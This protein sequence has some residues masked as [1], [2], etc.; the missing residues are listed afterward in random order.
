MNYQRKQFRALCEGITTSPP[1]L[2][3]GTANYPFLQNV[4]T[5][6]QGV[7]ETRPG[8]VRLNASALADTNV[9]SLRR[10]NDAVTGASFRMVGAGTSLYTQNTST[11]AMTLRASG[12]S[13]APLSS[14]I[15]RPEQSPQAWM[16]LT[17]GTKAG[18]LGIVASVPTYYNWGIASPNEAPAAALTAPAA[19]E[20][21]WFDASAGWAGSGAAAGAIGTTNRINTTI[22]QILYDAGSTGYASCAPASMD[23]NFQPGVRVR[24]NSGG[25]TDEYVLINSVYPAPSSTTISDI[26]Y[27]SGSTGACTI[28][29]AAASAGLVVNSLLRLNA[30]ENVRVQAISVGPDGLPSIRT[31]TTGTFS[32]GQ[33]VDGL[34][35]FRAYFAA[36]H[37][38]AETITDVALT[39]AISGSGLTHLTR[40]SALNLSKV[41]A[42]PVQDS[43][44]IHISIRVDNLAGFTE[45][46]IRL[47][48]DGATNDFTRNYFTFSF[49]P[50]DLTPALSQTAT[51][52]S[53]QQEALA[54]SNVQSIYARKYSDIYGPQDRDPFLGDYYNDYSTLSGISTGGSDVPL[55]GQTVTGNNQWTELRFKVGQLNRVGSDTTR[56]LANV[57]AIR[58]SFNAT[59]AINVQLD[60]WWVG[61]TYGPDVG[62]TGKSYVYC[63]RARSSITGARSNPSPPMRVGLSPRRERVQVTLTQHADAQVDYLDV[64]RFGGSLIN[65]RYI[66]SVSNGVSPVFNDDYPDSVVLANEGLEFDNYQ[67]FP[68]HDTPHSGVVSVKGNIVEWVSGDKFN[69]AW[70]RGTQI[71]INGIPYT[72]YARPSSDQRVELGEN[73]GS[74]TSVSYSVPEGL[75]AGQPLEHVWGPFGE[76]QTGIFIF[77]CGNSQQPGTLFW[78]RADSP[79]TASDINQL[80]ITSP[81]EPLIAGGMY[82]GRPF[83]YSSERMFFIYPALEST[84][85]TDGVPEER[86]SFRAQE[87]A[88]SKGLISRHALA[89]GPKIYFMARDGVYESEGGEPRLISG[90][91]I[92]IFGHDGQNGVTTN[93]IP[94][95]DLSQ[96]NKLRLSYYD[97]YLYVN[98]Q[99]VAAPQRTLI[100]DTR[101]RGW[102]LDTYIPGVN[103]HY[104][105]EGK[106]LHSLILAAT[107]GRTYALSGTSDQ[108]VGIPCVV[109]WPTWDGGD[110]RPLK[111]YGDVAFDL[112]T[113]AS[114]LIPITA[115]FYLDSYQTLL[116][117]QT[118]VR[119]TTGRE[120]QAL[121]LQSGAGAFAHDL[122]FQLSWTQVGANQV[123]LYGADISW[124]P[125]PEASSSRYT[126]WFETGLGT[127]WW[128]GLRLH[129]NTYGQ[130]RSIRVQYQDDTGAVINGPDLTF[131]LNGETVVTRSWTPF[132]A[133]KVRLAPLD[134]LPWTVLGVEWVTEPEPDLATTWTSQPTGHGLPGWQHIREVWIPLR[135]TA[136]AALTITVDGIAYN[137]SIG[138]TG[139]ALNKVWLPTGGLKGRIFQYSITEPTTGVRVYQKDIEVRCKSWGTSGGYQIVR[140]LGDAHNVNGALL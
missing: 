113:T 111:L 54:R 127:R 77:G 26:S 112:E 136:S 53:T 98:Y 15:A 68:V 133:R 120:W 96:I 10:L 16:Y 27:D 74:Q 75:V 90:G 9:H 42:R 6:T 76:G 45:G 140:P 71:V 14:V 35:S 135:S 85:S 44:E 52:I 107:D 109:R 19:Q 129:G 49:R 81:A 12:F 33:T 123:S 88:N 84:L 61:G 47:D 38:A 72:L 87:V 128:Q 39:F 103:F 66:G 13:G 114:T 124:V 97:S 57:A 83:V 31:S 73:A 60:S 46:Q 40:T 122:G 36:N 8:M 22:S 59:A 117:T 51:T 64:Y 121:S 56:G 48:F 1:E 3:A 63:Y 134:S 82:D 50:N 95:V 92:E 125:R 62:D 18:K 55:P 101:I 131:N 58:I 105:E 110:R 23:E 28:V 118:I 4:R 79:D 2:L 29:L 102:L 100:Y 116:E 78:T 126:D 91:L 11:Q 89:V 17:D 37:A 24:I 65:W 138:S 30:S 132:I 130:T 20:I 34:R 25:G 32:A 137:Y 41:G 7:I 67:P 70:E 43:D 99:S 80:E 115:D 86:I 106:G 5:Y 119:S 104:G 108:G 93:N 94:G 21:D 69:T 139:G